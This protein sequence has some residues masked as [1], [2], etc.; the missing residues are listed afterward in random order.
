MNSNKIYNNVQGATELHSALSNPLQNLT[1]DF[2]E[3]FRGF[4]DAEGCFLIARTG[5]TFAFRFLIKFEFPFFI[6][7]TKLFKFLN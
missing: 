4:V 6:F 1:K 7:I 2:I 5:D 3:K